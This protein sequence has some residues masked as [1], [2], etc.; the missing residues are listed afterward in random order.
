M[1]LCSILLFIIWLIRG[2]LMRPRLISCPGEVVVGAQP[3]VQSAYVNW[4]EPVVVDDSGIVSL[5]GQTHFRG[6]WSVG[7]EET[8][9]YNYGDPYGNHVHCN[10]NVRVITDSSP[11]TVF[12]CPSDDQTFVLYGGEIANVSWGEPFATDESTEISVHQTHR[13]GDTFPIGVTAVEYVFEDSAGNVA[14]CRFNIRVNLLND[15]STAPDDG[16]NFHSAL[17]IILVVAMV[18][19]MLP[20]LFLNVSIFL[21]VKRSAETLSSTGNRLPTDCYYTR[22]WPQELPSFP[23]D[24]LSTTSGG[25]ERPIDGPRGV[26]QAVPYAN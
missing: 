6:S 20:T 16:Q 26:V 5:F 19:L 4:E 21:S 8:V 18:V 15:L 17:I 12:G 3:G 24:T 25:Y 2:D 1:L 22:N 11:P 9:N 23:R 7:T 10:F 13:P 14:S